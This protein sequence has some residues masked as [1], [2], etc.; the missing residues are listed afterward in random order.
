MTAEAALAKRTD[1]F[2]F[3]SGY[4]GA[5]FRDSVGETDRT[6][7]IVLNGISTPSSSP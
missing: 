4:I 2:L 3:E 5:R 7:R 1:V 6:V